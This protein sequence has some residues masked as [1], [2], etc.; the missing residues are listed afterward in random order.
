[1]CNYNT[2]YTINQ[3]SPGIFT[4]INLV[5]TIINVITLIVLNFFLFSPRRK[6]ERNYQLQ[7]ALF[8][9]FVVDNIRDIVNYSSEVVNI[10]LSLEVDCRFTAINLKNIEKACDEIESLNTGFN[11]SVIPIIYN[12]NEIMASELKD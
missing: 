12:Y 3:S 7:A 1:M 4:Y 2:Y 6:N 5:L 10:P 11:N 8:K 9:S